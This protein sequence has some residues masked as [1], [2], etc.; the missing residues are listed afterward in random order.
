LNKK[1]KIILGQIEDNPHEEGEIEIN[2]E[3]HTI[4]NLLSCGL[5]NHKN[6]QF[7]GY[8]MPH[9]LEKRVIISYKLKSG[10]FKEILKE[11]IENFIDTFEKIDKEIETSKF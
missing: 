9:P 1:L 8:H 4:G 2:Q 3:D 5:Q 11:V 10:K 6:V 7:A